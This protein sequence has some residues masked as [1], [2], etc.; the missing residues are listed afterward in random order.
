MQTGQFDFGIIGVG[1]M[2]SNLLLN[3]ADHGFK[4]LGY[5]KNHEKTA[6][7]ENSARP[8]TIVKGVNTVSEMMELLK[9]PRKIML[10]V[11]AGKIV[12]DVIYD[13][14]PFVEQGDILVDGGNS[15]YTDTLKRISFLQ[16]KGVH[17]MGAGISGGEEG[18]RV[19]PSIM[20]G[21]DKEAYA[22][23]QPLFES[24]AAKVNYEPCVA[25]LGKHAAGHYV[26]M[27]HNGIEYSIMQMISEVYAVLKQRASLSNDELSEVFKQW[28]DGELQCFLVEITAHIFKET[29]DK[30]GNRLVDMILDKAGAKGTGKWTSQDALDISVAVPCIDAAVAMRNLSAIKQ[31]RLKASAIYNGVQH[32][33][34]LSK[35]EWIGHLHDALLFGIITS[36]AQ[37]LAM[38]QVASVQLD[39]QIDIVK[40]VSVWKGGCIIRSRLLNMLATAFLHENN[41]E[42]I[43]L[44][45]EVAEIVKRCEPHLRI[46]VADAVQAGI[47]TAGLSAALH[48]F[49]V[50]RNSSLPV[51]LIQAQRDFF[52]AHTYERT[53]EPGIFHTEW[54]TVK[55]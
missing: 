23:L 11:P 17:F 43:L 20:P 25:Y 29:D 13:L 24:V 53:D 16:A 48:Y 32:D 30:T 21:G 45:H 38:L 14:L 40:V 19:G 36:Y 1:V 52:G 10:L 5:D 28:N 42:N 33:S 12:D 8:N 51:N 50:Y 15:H 27:V 37:G 2:G 47:A 22:H 4:V 54:N 55:P 39:M 49:D 41:L 34:L 9:H 35:E 3:L 46:V 6:A 44:N 18:A 7:L 26:K 31:Q